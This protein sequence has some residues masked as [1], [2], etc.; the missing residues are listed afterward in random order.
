MDPDG[1]NVFGYI[2]LLFVLILLNAFF[3]MSEIAIISLNDNKVRRMAADGDKKAK[4]LLRL[5]ENPNNFL[6]TIQIGVTLSGFL[7]S[8][9]AADTFADLASKALKSV[10]PM[11][12]SALR[13]LCLIV[14]TIL[15]SY[16]TLVLG[17]LVPKRVAMQNY[18]KI[19]FAIAGV[20][21]G[22][23]TV[24]KP[25][26][27]FLS[28]STNFVLRLIRIDP[29]QKPEEVTEEEIRLL[30]DAGNE[31]GQIHESDKDMIYNIFEFDDTYIEDIM[32]HRTEI[33]AVELNASLDEI[34]ATA[35]ESGY[36]RIPIYNEDLDDVVG[37][38]YVKDLLQF[39]INEPNNFD[40]HKFLRTPLY[41][42]E[43][44][45]L[46]AL[47]AQFK[48]TK[49]QMAIVIDEYGGTAGLVTMEDLLESIVGN[50]QDEYDDEEEE[51]FEVSDN[52]Y[53][54][55]GL[56]PVEDVFKFF[57]LGVVPDEDDFDTIGGYILNRLGQ[58]PSEG[59]CPS[60]AVGDVVFTVS[61]MEERRIAKLKADRII[62]EEDEEELVDLSDKRKPSGIREIISGDDEQEKSD[63]K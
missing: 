30:L 1:S 55:D 59:D 62:V 39:A 35:V 56:T 42:I 6:S 7:A 9:V 45:N 49:I 10:V 21:S 36:S 58:I 53:I 28:A 15:L 48:E 46:K 23:M 24:M 22:F 4:N 25:F 50:I 51:I 26:V 5:I 34:I 19:S 41:T 29:N 11:S 12:E 20:L 43:T 60:V 37:V 16:I 14:I 54:V 3:A 47:F 31:S 61:D 44:T 18:E 38:I 57:E 8:A 13:M 17:E 2:I 63:L 33:V 32:T 40:I 52:S 27:T